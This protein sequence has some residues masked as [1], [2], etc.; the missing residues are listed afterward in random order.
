MFEMGRFSPDFESLWLVGAKPLS[1]LGPWVSYFLENP[2]HDEPVTSEVTTSSTRTGCMFI[3]YQM[4][5]L[6]RRY[7][8]PLF[9]VGV[10]FVGRV[11]ND[12]ST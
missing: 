2:D 5:F 9:L 11:I 12:Y 6:R 10:A 4:V 1:L 3:N 7:C 8:K